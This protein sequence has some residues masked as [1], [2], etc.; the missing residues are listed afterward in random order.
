MRTR[1]LPLLF[2]A[3]LTVGAVFLALGTDRPRS[4]PGEAAAALVPPAAAVRPALPALPPAPTGEAPDGDPQAAP[5]AGDGELT[6]G[7]L[8]AM[9]RTLADLTSPCRSALPDL[10]LSPPFN[11]RYLVTV[12]IARGRARILKVDVDDTTASNEV[13]QVVPPPVRQCLAER[14]RAQ[15]WEVSEGA[16]NQLHRHM[17]ALNW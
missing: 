13:A 1:A 2:G 11:L 16:R 15:E 8:I 14:L 12:G 7:D 9:D 5:A 4:S 10:G 6:R 3:V 17:T